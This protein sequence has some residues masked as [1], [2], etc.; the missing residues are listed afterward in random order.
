[1]PGAEAW[2]GQYVQGHDWMPHFVEL[3]CTY[4][5]ARLHVGSKAAQTASTVELHSLIFHAGSVTSPC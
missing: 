4:I 1:M 5:P 2:P 3:Q